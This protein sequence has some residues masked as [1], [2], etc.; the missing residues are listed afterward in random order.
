MNL[1]SSDIFRRA[2]TSYAGDIPN[3]AAMLEEMINGKSCDKDDVK[4]LLLTNNWYAR[5]KPNEEIE[6][7]QIGLWDYTLLSWYFCLYT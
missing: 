1:K 6:K 2:I 5:L 4:N 3:L 7:S